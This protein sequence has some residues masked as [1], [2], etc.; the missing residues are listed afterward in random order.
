MT[1]APTLADR[2]V[3]L[4]LTQRQLGERLGVSTTYVKQMELGRRLDP[5]GRLRVRAMY[6]LALCELE[7][8]AG[9]ADIV[10]L[11]RKLLDEVERGSDEVNKT[12]MAALETACD[13]AEG[14]R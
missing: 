1:D 4:G 3:A 8:R 7:R 5:K 10:A 6:E 11:A 9:Q 2:R 14:R 12:T 13:K